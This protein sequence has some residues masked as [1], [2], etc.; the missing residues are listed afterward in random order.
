[1]ALSLLEETDWHRYLLDF[2]PA[3]VSYPKERTIHGLF[4]DQVETT[5]EAEALVLGE[6]S[7][8]YRELDGQANRLARYLRSA[9]V[10][11]GDRV[12]VLLHHSFEMVVAVLG[13]LKAGASYVPLDP[14]H[15]KARLGYLIADS[16]AKLTLTSRE[17]R[18]RLPE[19]GRAVV[20]EEEWE[21]IAAH[22]T[23][24]PGG[25]SSSSDEPAYV[26]YTS[27][28]TGAPKGVQVAHSSLVNY[29]CWA[30]RV[31]LRGEVLDFPLH[32]SLAFDLTMTSL[33]VPLVTGGR[34]VIYPQRQDQ[35]PL[36]D[37]MG[38]GRVEAVKLTPSH[39]E[40]IKERDNRGSRIR[41]LIVGGEALSSA[42]ARQVEDSF[43]GEVEI[44]NE[45][46]PTEATVGCM[47]HR[48]A[49]PEHE[50]GFVPIGK[51]AANVQLYVLDRSLRPVA[52]NIVGELY[53]AGDCLAMGYLNR[54]E[55]TAEK[56][57]VNPFL[58]GQRMYRSGDLARW[59]PE[60]SLDFVGRADEQVKVRGYRIELNEIRI[61][62][63]RHPEVRDSVV[64]VAM[65]AQGPVLVAYH[66]SKR[67]LAQ[68]ALHDFLAE[69]LLEEAIPSVFVHL[70]RLPL[71]LNGKVNLQALPTLAEVRK[72]SRPGY[73]APRNQAEKILAEIWSSLLG[74]V[75]V[76][77]YD[78]FFQLGGDSI[79]GIRIVARANQAGFQLAPRQI[80][81][82]QTVAELAAAAGELTRESIDSGPVVGPAPLTPI[83]K[84]FFAGVDVAPQHY[85]QAMLLE[86]GDREPATEGQ[87]AGGQ[88]SRWR[89]AFARLLDHHDALRSR[90]EPTRDGWRQIYGEPGGEP[91]LTW[92]D[93]SQLSPAGWEEACE[94][95]AA[96]LQRSLD[97]GRGPLLRAAL[98]DFGP[99]T[100]ALLLIAIHHLVMDAVSWRILLEDLDTILRGPSP[101]PAR[102]TSFKV[103]AEKLTELAQSE[104]LA[105]ELPYWLALAA[106]QVPALPLDFPGGINTVASS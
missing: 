33:Y 47:V 54:P 55:L 92:F 41:C 4:Q 56:F 22:E 84:Y 16:G 88:P 53:L 97:L 75:E 105:E 28:S 13:V 101:L 85:N 82:F 69:T 78:N 106:V 103:W 72:R 31:Y 49:R 38:E 1:A 79:V 27:G 99:G 18:A 89:A 52:E 68:Q 74:G 102:T 80:F 5:P 14:G 7:L 34:L 23:D 25:V 17:L 61:A 21:A 70:R 42:L 11:D 3:A 73:V 10:A 46:G 71:T 81:Q 29:I 36:L 62:L 40:L 30:A 2:Q 39:L 91:P 43:G 24:P 51:P 44:F 20:L 87:P 63:N 96:S 64:A 100:A 98:F 37:L 86:V 60:G 6:R 77:V 66:V 48:F 76:G 104:A 8:S 19:D 95:A 26:I 45:Y 15:P 59:L 57:L 67:E 32:T 12:A 50:G 90:F 35:Y 93:L 65:E 94:A 83:Q 9:G 58:P